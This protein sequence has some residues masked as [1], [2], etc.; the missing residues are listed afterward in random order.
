MALTL[1]WDFEVADVRCRVTWWHGDHD[2]NAPIE[3]V[4]RLVERM[5]AVDL[6]V[7]TDVGHLEPFH[8][9][10]DI[11]CELLSR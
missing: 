3:P 4:R 11:L 6:R 10:E 5:H 9:Y 2:A 7:W 8:R 1:D